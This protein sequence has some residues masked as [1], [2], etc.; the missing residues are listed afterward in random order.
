MQGWQWAFRRQRLPVIILAASLINFGVGALQYSIQLHLVSDKTQ[1]FRIGLMSTGICAAMLIGSVL[2]NRLRGK[3]H[4]GGAVCAAFALILVFATPML[5][6]NTYWVIFVCYAMLGLP[7]PLI[8]T[9]MLV[10]VFSKT[11][12]NLQ[13]L[14]STTVSL[15][16]QALSMLCS[17]IAG[18]LLPA[19]GFTATLGLFLAAAAISSLIAV[20]VPAIRTISQSSQ[21]QDTR[22]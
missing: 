8:N 4:V 12:E 15:P 19:F 9:A 6:N 11:A 21:W 18:T 7:V 16:A 13:G 2:A 10:F 5:F 22:L 17:G 3:V 20:L 14:V 1:P